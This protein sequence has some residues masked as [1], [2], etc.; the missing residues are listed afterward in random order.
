M[1]ENTAKPKTRLNVKGKRG[2]QK[3]LTEPR[4]IN[5]YLQPDDIEKAKAIGDGNASEGVRLALKSY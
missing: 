4:R 1:T 5:M 2:F 3:T